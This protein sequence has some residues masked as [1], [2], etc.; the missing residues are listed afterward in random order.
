MIHKEVFLILQYKYTGDLNINHVINEIEFGNTFA[1]YK[2]REEII[3]VNG[4]TN[5]WVSLLNLTNNSFII[6]IKKDF[7][8]KDNFFELLMTSFVYNLNDFGNIKLDDIDIS[9][10]LNY[11]IISKEKANVFSHFPIIGTI[12]KPYYHLSLNQ[13]IKFTRNFLNCGGKLI[14]EDETYLVSKAKILKET[15]YIRAEMKS[16]GI[17][18]PNITPHINDYKF[19]LEL[20]HSG[21]EVVMVNFLITS[22]RSVYE[23]KR[24][25]PNISI[26]GHRVGY[27]S[28]KKYISMKALSKIVTLAGIDYLHIGTPTNKKKLEE[29]LELILSVRKTKRN[30]LPIFSKIT[31]ELIPYLVNA[32]GEN[33]I[34]MTCGYIRNSKST[35]ID[36]EKTKN[37]I[38]ISKLKEQI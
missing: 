35:D 33:I 36:W 7:F 22:L 20:Y 24:K 23:L 31:P 27:L 14:K 6:K 32:F 37:L 25:I 13:K 16:N 30:F 18:I 1:L 12:F 21:I 2:N 28:I 38:Q 10:F 8:S 17:Y 5:K 26:W 29:K 34:L 11:N 3:S 4:G 9:E 19:I 15:K